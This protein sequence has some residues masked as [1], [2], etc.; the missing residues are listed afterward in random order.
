[1]KYLT[2]VL[3]NARRNPVRSL[4][5]IASTGVSL[6][7]M[8]ILFSFFT[9]NDEVARESRVYNRIV[10]LNSQGFSGRLPIVRV[11]EIVAMDGVIAATPFTWYGGKYGEETLPFAQ[12]GVD[13]ESFLS[14]YDEF[15]LPP[16]QLKAWR[17]DRAGCIVGRKLARDRGFKVGDPLPLKGDAYPFDL[18]LTVRGIYDGPDNRDLRMCLFQWDYLDEGLKQVRRGAAA[19]NAVVIVTKCKNGDLMAPLSRKIDAAYLNTDAPTRTQTEE[20]FDRMF[21]EMLGDLKGMVRA[22]GMAVVLSLVLVSANALA[23]ALRERTTEVAVLKAIGFGRQLILFLI[24]AEAM[25]V[26]GVGGLLGAIGAKLFFDAVDVGRYSAGLLPFFFVPWMTAL[27][28][29]ALSVLIG[30]VSGL[31]PAARAARLSVVN[32][33]RKVV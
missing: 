4:L 30:F 24:L 32:G 33:L 8:M 26:S 31:F 7:L 1:M 16:D 23:M 13:P 22:I 12:F 15:T 6:F 3:R 29:L 11:K 20:A 14:I 5:T 25:I 19:G 27:A 21:V 18:T 2:Y 17:E 28:G 10:T 9:I